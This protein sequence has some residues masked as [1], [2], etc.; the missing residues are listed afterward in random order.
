M[1]ASTS[2]RDDTERRNSVE[3]TT[4]GTDSGRYNEDGEVDM[5]SVSD[6]STGDGRMRRLKSK[7]VDAAGAT[8]VVANGKGQKLSRANMKKHDRQWASFISH[9]SHD[10]TNQEQKSGNHTHPK[11][12]NSLEDTLDSI[13]N[14]QKGN[15]KSSRKKKKKKRKLL[16]PG[17]SSSL[18]RSFPLPGPAQIESYLKEY[19]SVNL[20]TRSNSPNNSSSP[21]NLSFE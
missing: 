19:D 5:G 9:A 17:V 6:N 1:T 20:N 15:K 3:A 2:V 10:S 18:C 4:S 12:T 7:E 14:P 16:L 21:D 13:E 8:V 11:P